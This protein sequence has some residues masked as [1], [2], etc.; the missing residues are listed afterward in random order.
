MDRCNSELRDKYVY[1]EKRGD[2]M[3]I[4]LDALYG[5]I[6]GMVVT[7]IVFLILER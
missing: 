4:N 6:I 3:K 7:V 5:L 2:G 1:G